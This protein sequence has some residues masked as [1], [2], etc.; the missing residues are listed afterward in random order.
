MGT[1][2]T[3]NIHLPPNALNPSAP[4]AMP[5]DQFVAYLEVVAEMLKAKWKGYDLSGIP[6]ERNQLGRWLQNTEEL[7]AHLLKNK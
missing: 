3:Y 2:P 1:A 4:D 7:A 5:A 6:E